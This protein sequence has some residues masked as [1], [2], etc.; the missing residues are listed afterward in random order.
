MQEL[1]G[2]NL[3]HVVEVSSCFFSVTVR[4]YR[5]LVCPYPVTVCVPT[6]ASFDVV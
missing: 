2:L 4:D 5:P 6:P 1:A 3:S